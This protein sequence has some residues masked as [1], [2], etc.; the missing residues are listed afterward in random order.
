MVAAAGQPFNWREMATFILSEGYD[1]EAAERVRRR[2]A[3]EYYRA[4]PTEPP[5]RITFRKHTSTIERI[6]RH[7]H[8]TFFADSQSSFLSG[9]RC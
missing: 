1:E 7:V 6:D 3:R 5:I 4:E 2:I 8:F 9:M